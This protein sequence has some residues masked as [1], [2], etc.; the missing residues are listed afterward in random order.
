MKTATFT[1]AARWRGYCGF[2]ARDALNWER[3]AYWKI[4]DQKMASSSVCRAP[5]DNVTEIYLRTA[6]T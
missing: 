5:G 6:I 1:L 4:L 3:V 2:D